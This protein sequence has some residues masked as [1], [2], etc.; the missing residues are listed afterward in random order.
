MIL[1]FLLS[2]LLIE[3]YLFAN[4]D[5]K[6]ISSKHELARNET[7][8]KKLNKKLYTIA[9]NIKREKNSLKN[10]DS[11]L[12]K[13]EKDINESLKD[14]QKN[15]EDLKELQEK[16]KK[17]QKSS[18]SLKEEM[19]LLVAKYFS[20]SLAAQNLKLENEED[21]VNEEILNAVKKSQKNKILNV[22]NMYLSVE[23]RLKSIKTKIKQ[24]QDKIN[25]LDKKR[26]EFIKLK[27][28]K[29]KTLLSY[30]K[31]KR[32][33]KE[34]I[35][36]LLEEQKSLRE[37]IERLKILQSSQKNV[38]TKAS[39]VKVRKLGKSYQ[40][41][42]TIKYRGPKTIPPLK[43][44]VITKRYGEYV[45]PIYK[46]K[47]F[48]ESI[49]LKPLKPNEKVRSILNGKVVLAKRTPHLN[50]VVIIK[51]RGN[52]YTIYA[53]IDKI[54]PTIKKGKVVRKGYVIG[55]VNRK[56]TFEVTKNRYHINPLDLIKI[57]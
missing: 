21:I 26:E 33:Y 27:K 54:A 9:I 32:E 1:N 12:A 34:S 3:A 30:V 38:H 14:Y 4:I 36:N 25:A 10:I 56:L 35:E 24:L 52:L 22:N 11:S 2:L 13:L 50:N 40:Y 19:T 29:E 55:R 43:R 57:D 20:K 18:E 7:K 39:K 48:N 37:T 15:V 16:E 28:R 47:I 42:K 41:V 5:K 51:H 49:E 31:R 8:L 23:K 44:F 17:L 6:I 45:D 53:N 46:I